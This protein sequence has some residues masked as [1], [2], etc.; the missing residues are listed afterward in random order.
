VQQFKSSVTCP[1]DNN[2]LERVGTSKVFDKEKEDDSATS[3]A[4]VTG[5]FSPFALVMHVHFG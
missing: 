3:P 4:L 2:L 1:T 5:Y